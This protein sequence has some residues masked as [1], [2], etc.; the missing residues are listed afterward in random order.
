MN[1]N[2]FNFVIVL[3][4]LSW[5]CFFYGLWGLVWKRS[6]RPMLDGFQLFLGLML[7]LAGLAKF[8]YMVGHFEFP[9]T[10]GPPWIE[11]KLAPH[12]LALLGRMLAFSQVIA[13]ALLLSGRFSTLGAIVA[14]PI[15]LMIT[16]V[17][18]SQHWGIA[19]VN[20]IFLAMNVALLLRDWNKLKF[21][22]IDDH[23][24]MDSIPF[25]RLN[26]KADIICLLG[27]A[28]ILIGSML[29]E[30]GII[31]FWLGIVLGLLLFVLCPFVAARKK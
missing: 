18:V 8:A 9:G 31:P 24:L 17:T 15:F 22:V 5:V 20:K 27:I 23:V 26:P 7:L 19:F 4:G 2:S 3:L 30:Y 21:L 14:F 11:E 25:R 16:A 10:I 12:G 29:A 28:C 6:L 1:F 13:G